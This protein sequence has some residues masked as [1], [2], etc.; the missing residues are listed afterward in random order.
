MFT[1][2][3]GLFGSKG[4]KQATLDCGSFG[5]GNFN[6]VLEA[7]PI[8]AAGNSL[9]CGLTGGGSVLAILAGGNIVYLQFVNGSST[10]ADLEAAITAS[11]GACGAIIKT[12]STNQ[13]HVL[14]F[15]AGDFFS[16]APFSGGVG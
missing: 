10:I 8:G 9:V 3:V 4:I 12:P 7:V 14:S 16:N 2:P 13:A 11:A 1:V 15:G 6:T 5:S